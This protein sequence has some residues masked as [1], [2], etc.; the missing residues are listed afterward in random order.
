MMA[1]RGGI[2]LRRCFFENL[3][4]RLLRFKSF[5]GFV[6]SWEAS[7]SCTRKLEMSEQHLKNRSGSGARLELV[8]FVCLSASVIVVVAIIIVSLNNYRSES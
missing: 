7:N 1:V 3:L 4:R 2:L 8:G 6:E 5:L